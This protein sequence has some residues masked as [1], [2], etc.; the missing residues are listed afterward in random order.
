[1]FHYEVRGPAAWL[2]IDDPDRRN[3]LSLAVIEMLREGLGSASADEQVRVVVVTGAGDRAFSAGGDLSGGFFDRPIE[4][5]HGRGAFAEMLRSMRRLGKPTI[6]RVNG[7]A[8]AG[9][10]GL[11]A[12]C[13]IVVA[14]EHARFGTPEIDVG[15]WPMMIG[16]VL[17]RCMPRRAVL[18]LMLTGRLIDASEAK[19]LGAVS[20]V[21]PSDR[22]DEEIDALVGQLA[23]KS[24]ATIRLG[25]DAFY[26]VDNLDFDEAL[27]HLHAALTSVASTEDAAE[28]VRA[29]LE[30][31]PPE[32]MGR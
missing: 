25:R 30:K 18:E 9:G 28:G 13:D 26:A 7:H 11:A 16:A 8:L 22:L 6:A 15:L 27:D 2:I 14:A 19:A 21:V 29:F 3:P 20:R 4:L 12:A 17:V 5:H 31:R 1:M 23:A 10:F 32:W 24:P